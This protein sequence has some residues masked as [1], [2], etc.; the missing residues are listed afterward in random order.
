MVVPEPVFALADLVAVE[1]VRLG[2]GSIPF[3]FQGPAHRQQ[4]VAAW[5]KVYAMRRE[6]DKVWK[7][8]RWRFDERCPQVLDDSGVPGFRR[9]YEA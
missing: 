8:M 1:D 6:A 5:E 9:R 2:L 3:G 7:L 4:V